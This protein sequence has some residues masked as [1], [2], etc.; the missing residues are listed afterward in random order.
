LNPDGS[1]FTTGFTNRGG[2][3]FWQPW[4]EV[5]NSGIVDTTWG[6][7]DVGTLKYIN[8]N[9]PVTVPTT[10]YNFLARGNFEIN[11]WIGV[12]GQGMFSHSTTYT[13][14]EPG[15][16]TFGWDVL[17]PWGDGR[18]TGQVPTFFGTY[19]NPAVPSSVTA[20]GTT[21]PQFIN[22]IP[23]TT[24]R[25]Y[26][27]ILPCATPGSPGYNDDG[28]SNREVFEQVVP[29]QLAALLDARTNPNAPISL[30]GFLPNLRE[31]Y[32]DVTTYTLVA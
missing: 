23:G 7:T 10:R 24:F 28:C 25:G 4:P 15:P 8:A 26:N 17:I 12:F 20:G 6:T 31:T 16:I 32:S 1:V 18:Y 29:A 2:S 21:N 27:G 30:S 5:D 3:A 14:Q 19:T 11:D 9:T 22:G 13:A